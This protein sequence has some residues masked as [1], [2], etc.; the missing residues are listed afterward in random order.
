MSAANEIKDLKKIVGEDS[1]L[2]DPET[3]DAYSKDYSLVKPR[4]P[5]MVVKAKNKDE[6]VEIV[7]YANE[8][9]IAICPRSSR[10]G[11]YGAGIP[12]QGGMVLDLTGMDKILQ[13]DTRARLVKVEPGVTVK[14]LQ[15]E[16]SSHGVM[17]QLPLCSHPEKSALTSA[18][19]REPM[20]IPKDEHYETM[21]NLEMVLATGETYYTGS[22]G[23]K[24]FRIGAVDEFFIPS[25]RL[26]VGAQGA[27]GIITAANLKV[28]HL[29][30]MDRLYFMPFEKL[31]D[32]LDPIR[33]IQWRMLGYE[34]F[35]LDRFTLAS[36]IANDSREFE[37]FREDM[38]L[39]T[40]VLCLSAVDRFP[41]EKI[42]YE[43]EALMEVAKEH[44]FD[45]C[46]TVGSVPGL[47]RR[48]L[49]ILRSPWK[50]DVYWKFQNKGG[51]QDIFFIAPIDRISEFTELMEHIAARHGYSSR[52]MGKYFQ[53]LYRANGVYC[54][55]GLPYDP[56]N[57]RE[58][59][60]IYTL[61]MD[62][63]EKLINEGAFFSNPYGPWADMVYSRAGK[64]PE[65]LRL[66]KNIFDPNQ[67]MNPG[68]LCF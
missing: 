11:F 9:K 59:K 16:L 56:T 10:V 52:D 4:K 62:A 3:L 30:V 24:G 49:P 13:V 28:I 27:F 47:N 61:F 1:V 50:K 67:I 58:T 26:F 7:K 51:C 36:I 35:V 57:P 18:M 6:V 33:K 31:E 17:M 29:P 63:S 34:C 5:R 68:K 21:V 38:P 40:L 60:R 55:F 14:K 45:I 20:M 42:E 32:L 8:N 41:E 44:D 37:V 64:Y 12:T 39:Y 46:R 2:N 15:G 54:Q 22:A 43:E 25:T 48:L 53:P 66:V 23:F 65:F 19:Q